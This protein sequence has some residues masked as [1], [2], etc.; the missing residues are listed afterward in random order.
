MR[1]EDNTAV[2]ETEQSRDEVDWLTL[3][4]SKNPEAPEFAI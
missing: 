2:L 1:R 3:V 4:L